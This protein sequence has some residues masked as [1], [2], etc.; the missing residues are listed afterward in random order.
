ML[1]D[2]PIL[3]YHLSNIR[4]LI[5]YGVSYLIVRK[6]TRFSQIF[7]VFLANTA[8]V[9]QDSLIGQ[10]FLAYFLQRDDFLHHVDTDLTSILS[11]HRLNPLKQTLLLKDMPSDLYN[12]VW[13]AKLQH[14]HHIHQKR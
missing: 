10:E 9:F 3:F 13:I 7:Y 5:E 11:W 12:P 2:D 4:D 8:K 14:H 6:N 1:A